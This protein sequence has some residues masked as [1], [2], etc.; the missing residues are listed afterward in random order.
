MDLNGDGKM[1]ILSGSY[2][3]DDE[4]MA[5]Y[6]QVLW[7]QQDGTFKKAQPLTG[8][9]GKQLTISV[10][11]GVELDDQDLWRI[12][13]RPTAVD[14]N[15]DGKLDLVAGNFKGSFVWFRGE[16][17]GKFAA[18]SQVIMAGD[19]PLL[20]ANDAMHSDPVVVDWD[21]DG[22]LDLLSGSGSGG[23]QWAE[24][25]A[26]KGKPASFTGFKEL[27]KGVGEDA[28]DQL[29]WKGAKITIGESTRIWVSDVNG[30]GK[31]DITLGDSTSQLIPANGLTEAQA[32]AK[33]AVW[34]MKM[35]ALNA[36]HNEME[37]A[38]SEDNQKEYFKVFDKL[39]IEFQTFADYHSSGHVWLY[40]QK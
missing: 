17:K 2:A 39:M 10:P 25:V 36:K 24:N 23:A 29:E 35:E 13:T 4:P 3:G 38:E 15:G 21:G 7:G 8:I 31:L 22:D 19:K 14:W 20:L 5:G 12:C 26:E 34:K 9:D 6:F 28:L 1:D 16:G 37:D 18:K 11:D 27:I 30:D 40:L 33:F 32:K